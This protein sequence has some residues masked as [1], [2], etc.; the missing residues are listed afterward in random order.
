MF[1]EPSE[2]TELLNC[3]HC[4]KPY[5]EYSPSKL[6]PCWGGTICYECVEKI[7]KQ[8]RNNKFKCIACKLEETIP[9][10]GFIVNNVAVKLITREANEILR[11]PE[12]ENLKQNL[13]DIE[14][15]VKKLESEM[16]NGDCFIF[17]DCNELRRQVQ[18]A[19][20]EK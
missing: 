4:L 14:S 1:Y 6:L 9:V 8:A 2:I 5:N 11:G 12:A 16:N 18:L 15:L 13:R 19:K 20:E 17:E 3:D 7:E 10:N